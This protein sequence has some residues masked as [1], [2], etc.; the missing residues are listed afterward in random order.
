[1]RAFLKLIR[2]ENLL[3]IIFIQF[4][5]RY[6]LFIPF[7]IE[8]ALPTFQFVLLVLATVFLAAGGYIIN[9]I[10]DI[11]ADTINRPKK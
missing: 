6:A 2:I 4:L 9:D 8:T 1:M 7:G 10:Q 5:I 11:V 3:F